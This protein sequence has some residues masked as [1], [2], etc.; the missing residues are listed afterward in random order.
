MALENTLQVCLT[1][2][3]TLFSCTLFLSFLWFLYMVVDSGDMEIFPFENRKWQ[4]KGRA[5]VGDKRSGG[6]CTVPVGLPLTSNPE[7]L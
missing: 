1:V 6:G 2:G 4:E 7:G 5:V 3:G